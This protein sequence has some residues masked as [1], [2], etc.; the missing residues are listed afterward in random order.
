MFHLPSCDVRT[1]YHVLTWEDRINTTSG[2]ESVPK[3]FQKCPK[4]GVWDLLWTMFGTC[5]GPVRHVWEYIFGKLSGQ[6][7]VLGQVRDIS[8]DMFGTRFGVNVNIFWEFPKSPGN[9]FNGNV[10]KNVYYGTHIGT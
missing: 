10:L 2:K 7:V 3:G 9:V 1:L 4:K 6:T 8:W 5:L